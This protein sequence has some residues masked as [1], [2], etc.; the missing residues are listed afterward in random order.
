MQAIDYP[1]RYLG[2]VVLIMLPVSLSYGAA[3][4]WTI[5][6]LLDIPVES[7][8]THNLFRAMMGLYLAFVAFWAYGYF[9]EK[10]RLTAIYTVIIFMLGVASGR[11]L[12]MAL[13]GPPSPML[14]F[15]TLSELTIGLT[16]VYLL[17]RRVNPY[18]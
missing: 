9:Q 2:I 5:P 17:Y 18:F 11:M 15:Y 8:N 14:I 13:D 10:Q 16:G 4:T 1:K 12:S 6:D 3:P 7:V